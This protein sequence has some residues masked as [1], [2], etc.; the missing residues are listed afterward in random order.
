MARKLSAPPAEPVP[1]QSDPVAQ[2]LLA[3]VLLR[4]GRQYNDAA[5]KEAGERLAKAAKPES[6][7]R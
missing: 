4:I 1:V 6:Y 5:I 7:A 2:A 3:K